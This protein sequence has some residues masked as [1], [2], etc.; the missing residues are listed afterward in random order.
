[1]LLWCLSTQTWFWS[2]HSQFSKYHDLTIITS[3]NNNISVSS[4]TV[5]NAIGFSPIGNCDTDFFSV[6]VP[7]GAGIHWLFVNQSS[8][9]R[10]LITDHKI[11]IINDWLFAAPPL[12]CGTNTGQHIYVP[13]CDACNVLSGY[14]AAKLLFCN[15]FLLWFMTFL[16]RINCFSSS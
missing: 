15:F 4:T 8:M 12:I 5:N 6:T 1:M 2:F 10:W 9:M 11:M 3:H 16:W 14:D 13:A 7:G